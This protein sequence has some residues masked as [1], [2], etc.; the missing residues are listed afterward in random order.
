MTDRKRFLIGVGGGYAFLL[1]LLAVRAASDSETTLYV[2][3]GVIVIGSALI[4]LLLIRNRRMSSVEKAA[5]R[6]KSAVNTLSRSFWLEW[7]AAMPQML[8]TTIIPMLLRSEW[9]DRRMFTATIIGGGM[10]LFV[11]SW[12][13]ER[14]RDYLA[15]HPETA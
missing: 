8:L 10:A 7:V 13:R 2:C 4:A 14:A 3:Y 9:D 5:T 12:K 6:L 1:S 15:K 11:A